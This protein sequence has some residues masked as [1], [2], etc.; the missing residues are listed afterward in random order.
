MI[1]LVITWGAEVFNRPNSR[2]NPL[3][4]QAE[5]VQYRA[6]RRITGAYYGSSSEKLLAIA[7]IEPLQAKLND[8]SNTWAARVLRTGDKT[9]RRFLEGPPTKDAWH[10]NNPMKDPTGGDNLDSPILAAF[11]LTFTDKDSLS[12]GNREDTGISYITEIPLLNADDPYSMTKL[13]W[14]AKIAELLEQG[15]T[16]VGGGVSAQDSVSDQPHN[17]FFSDEMGCVRG[18]IEQ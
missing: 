17:C 11:S 10:S 5:K 12:F 6:L 15:F 4:D 2:H 18:D 1:R 16:N 7:G 9:I 3:L 13:P 8:I 14:L